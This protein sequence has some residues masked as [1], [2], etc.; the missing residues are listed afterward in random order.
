[1]TKNPQLH[2]KSKHIAIKY[3]YIREQVSNGSLEL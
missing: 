1:M 2:G 3:H